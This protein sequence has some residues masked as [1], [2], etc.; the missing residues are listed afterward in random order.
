M[1]ATMPHLVP[2]KHLVRINTLDQTL[3][4]AASIGAP[5]FGI[6]LYTTLGFHAVMFLDFIGA[7][8]AV[9]GLAFAK[10]PV[11]HDETTKNQHVIANLMDGWHAFSSKRGLVI[12]LL[13]I[14]LV[15]V[16]FG[17]ARRALPA[18]DARAFRRGDGTWPP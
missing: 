11:T 6:F 8:A 15:M 3:A 12:L 10:I 7:A 4:S 18:H 5:V 14:T 17:T 1:M 2:E 13:G 9:A 16:V